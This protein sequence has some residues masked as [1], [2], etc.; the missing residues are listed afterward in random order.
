[1][2][3]IVLLVRIARCGRRRTA[4]RLVGCGIAPRWTRSPGYQ[5][6]PRRTAHRVNHARGVPFDCLNKR[7]RWDVFDFVVRLGK[8]LRQLYARIVYAFLPVPNIIAE[9]GPPDNPGAA[10]IVKDMLAKHAARRPPSY[11]SVAS[12]AARAAQVLG[13]ELGR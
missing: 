4:S 7:G 6:L 10:L 8:H 1:M 11:R 13:N 9:L 5:L 2:S 3:P 12:P